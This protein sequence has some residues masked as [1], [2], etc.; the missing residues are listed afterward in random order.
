MNKQELIEFEERV[1][2]KFNN[3]EIKAP[4]HLYYGNEDDII[5][6]FKNINNIIKDFDIN[7][8]GKSKP[9]F[10]KM[11]L[12]NLN[13]KFFQLMNYEDISDQL[14]N[15]DLKITSEFWKLIK[16]NINTLNDV[17]FWWNIIYGK[18]KSINNDQEFTHLALKT[19]PKDSFDQSTWSTWTSL[20]MKESGR[21]GKDLFKPLRLS[22]TGESNGPEMAN[23]VLTMGRD[24]I[25]ERLNNKD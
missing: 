9:K 10:D 13:S 21:K 18:I 15:L 12:S 16:G 25:V 22:L 2:E 6:V 11:E 1:A 14:N 19:L 24:K 4:V 3:A 17:K 7:K 23:L 5:E 8:F 20:L